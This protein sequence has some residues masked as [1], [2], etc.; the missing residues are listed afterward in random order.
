MIIMPLEITS[1]LYISI[2]CHK[3]QKH[4]SQANLRGGADTEVLCGNRSS[5]NMQYFANFFY[6]MWNI[7]MAAARI[8]CLVYCLI[9]VT[10]EPLVL[11]IWK[12]VW[13]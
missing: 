11:S 2:S 8:L 5:K 6:R 13:R 7:I 1:T 4:G 10:N 9:A 12:F 3:K